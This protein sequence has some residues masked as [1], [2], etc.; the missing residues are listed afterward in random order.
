MTTA[1][2][3]IESLKGEIKYWQAKMTEA[4][5][6]GRVAIMAVAD[7]AEAKIKLEEKL[8]GAVATEE[9]IQ[10]IVEACLVKGYLE[11]ITQM[12]G[13]DTPVL[14]ISVLLKQAKEA[15]ARGEIPFE[16]EV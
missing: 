13:T 4:K 5:R 14:P 16:K 15:W 6:C 11:T 10:R 3:Q 2:Q 9:D 12:D 8:A 7:M 1:E